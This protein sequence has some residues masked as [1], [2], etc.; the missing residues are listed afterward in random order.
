MP[1]DPTNISHT[2]EFI[3]RMHIKDVLHGQGCAEKIPASGVNNSLGPASGS[4][5]LK[6]QLSV[7][8]V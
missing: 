4:G 1:S 7:S 2:C 6:Q 5:S 3:V 8:I